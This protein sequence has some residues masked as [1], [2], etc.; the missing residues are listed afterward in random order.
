LAALFSLSTV[1]TDFLM[2]CVAAEIDPRLLERA[3]VNLLDNSIKYSHKGSAVQIEVAE[4]GE[5]VTISFK[6]R[7]IGIPREH[8]PRLFERFYRV[9]KGR[10]RKLGGTGL[11]LAIVKHVVQAH[12]GRVSVESLPGNSSVHTPSLD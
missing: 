8:L 7:G 3:F 5:E 6:D 1:E 11:G 10:S 2:L 12:R 4:T 9:D